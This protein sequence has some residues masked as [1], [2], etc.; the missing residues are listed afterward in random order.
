MRLRGRFI[1]E[2]LQAFSQEVPWDDQRYPAMRSPGK[3]RYVTRR[4]LPK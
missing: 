3:Q 1:D 2:Q 4:R